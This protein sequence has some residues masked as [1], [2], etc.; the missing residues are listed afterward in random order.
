MEHRTLSLTRVT[1]HFVT[2]GDGDPVV[3]L[4]GWPQ[5]S[6]EWRKVIPLLAPS[7]LIALPRTIARILRPAARATLRRSSATTTTPSPRP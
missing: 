1:L 2:A 4:H 6:H 5:T 3:L 7:W